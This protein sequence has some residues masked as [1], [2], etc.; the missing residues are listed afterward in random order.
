MNQYDLL[1]ALFRLRRQTQQIE[2]ADLIAK[3]QYQPRVQSVAF[4]LLQPLMSHKPFVVKPVRVYDVRIKSQ[5][6]ITVPSPSS[7]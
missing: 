3:D 6:G 4:G 7:C 1:L 2:I 5:V